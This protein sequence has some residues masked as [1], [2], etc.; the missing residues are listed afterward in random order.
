MT[1]RANVETG[2]ASAWCDSLEASHSAGKLSPPLETGGCHGGACP[3]RSAFPMG[4]GQPEGPTRQ[5]FLFL[6][7]KILW[8]IHNGPTTQFC[9]YSKVYCIPMTLTYLNTK[10]SLL[11]KMVYIFLKLCTFKFNKILLFSKPCPMV[12]LISQFFSVFCNYSV[13]CDTIL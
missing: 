6:F 10:G 2:L 12:A 3:F 7:F 9:G 5:T 8:L 4:G 13:F 1:R 11:L